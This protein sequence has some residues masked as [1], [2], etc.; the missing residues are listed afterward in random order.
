MR[1]QLLLCI[2]AGMC[3]FSFVTFSYPWSEGSEG[4]RRIAGSR[5]ARGKALY[6]ATCMAMFRYPIV[7]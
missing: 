2:E 1:M 5:R 3:Y 6:R 4:E 7:A